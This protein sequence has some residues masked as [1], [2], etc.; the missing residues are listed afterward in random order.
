[1]HAKDACIGS[2]YQKV[3]NHQNNLLY[4]SQIQNLN[5]DI[6]INR[7]QFTCGF[8]PAASF[9]FFFFGFLNAKQ[10]VEQLQRCQRMLTT[11]HKYTVQHRRTT[12]N[13]MHQTAFDY[14]DQVVP[15]MTK[16]IKQSTKINSE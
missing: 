14:N 10:D 5:I 11:D 7:I 8:T 2:P 16:D 6:E 4:T 9:F 1:M 12:V 3:T 15:F 13:T